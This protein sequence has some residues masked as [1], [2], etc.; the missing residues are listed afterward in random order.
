MV[1][2]HF[3]Q[4]NIENNI[5]VHT[6]HTI[7]E[8]RKAE[9]SINQRYDEIFKDLD[10]NTCIKS[11]IIF[12]VNV[13]LWKSNENAYT[14]ILVISIGPYHKKILNLTPW[15]STNCYTYN[16]FSSGK[17]RLMWKVASVN[18]SK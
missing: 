17:T 1:R 5:F 15:I 4:I 9:V 2:T 13:G 6:K 12:K 8:G 7:G 10:N 14:P 18:W 11:A 3:S 16:G